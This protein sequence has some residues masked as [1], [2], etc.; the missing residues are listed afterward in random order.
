MSLPFKQTVQVD[1]KIFN[2]E[3]LFKLVIAEPGFSL[4]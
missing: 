4:F 2:R 3:G 1:T